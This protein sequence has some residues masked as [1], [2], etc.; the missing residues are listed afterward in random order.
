M[1]AVLTALGAIIAPLLNYA[2]QKF[3]SI[4]ASF[5]AGMSV[6]LAGFT[7]DQRAIFAQAIAFWQA[8]YHAEIAAGSTPLSAIENASTATL[9]EFIKDE[10]TEGQKELRAV[11]A[12]LESSVKSNLS[13]S[14]KA[15]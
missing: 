9:N 15:A 5:L 6:I 14:A 13:T 3:E 8:R 11:I 2:E 10:E 4:G 1:N 12:L 7:S